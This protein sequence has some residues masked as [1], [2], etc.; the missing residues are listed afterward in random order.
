[1]FR[2]VVSID[3]VLFTPGFFN[4]LASGDDPTDSSLEVRLKRL[5]LFLKQ[6]VENEQ[7]ISLAA[8]GFGFASSMRSS[9]GEDG[10]FITNWFGM[11]HY[12]C[13][14][15]SGTHLSETCFTANRVCLE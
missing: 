13:L 8:E 1:M 9:G 10:E 12:L 6:E 15:C 2:H 3:R 14:F 4:S 5:M 11:P 7:H